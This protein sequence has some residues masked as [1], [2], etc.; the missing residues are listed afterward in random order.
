LVEHRAPGVEPSSFSDLFGRLVWLQA[1]NGSSILS[2]LSMWL[3]GDDFYGI[4]VALDLEEAF[5]FDSRAAMVDAFKRLE[6]RW[7]EV[8]ERCDEILVAW[9]KSVPR[10]DSSRYRELAASRRLLV[11]RR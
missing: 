11:S 3:E 5:L 6:S 4:R 1:D 8:S 2:V 7:P 9:D 10:S